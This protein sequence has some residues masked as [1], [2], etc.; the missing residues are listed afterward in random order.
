MV[1]HKP[2]HCHALDSSGRCPVPANHEVALRLNDVLQQL[3]AGTGELGGCRVAAG[4]AL[5]EEVRLLQ[6]LEIYTFAVT[7]CEG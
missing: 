2:T 5:D 7:H 1:G 4:Q 3:R 6:L